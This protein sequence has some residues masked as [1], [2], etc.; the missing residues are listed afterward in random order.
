MSIFRLSR[1]AKDTLRVFLAHRESSETLPDIRGLL[2]KARVIHVPKTLYREVVE[3]T[4]TKML[5][6]HFRGESWA[7]E[8][9]ER[10]AQAGL[11]PGD[12]WRDE[13]YLPLAKTV[14]SFRR[15]GPLPFP[16]TYVGYGVAEGEGTPLASLL[17]RLDLAAVS[18]EDGKPTDV[19]FCYPF[20][21]LLTEE[22]DV[23]QFSAVA[24]YRDPEDIL[25]NIRTL[26]VVDASGG[27][28]AD[29]PVAA[30]WSLPVLM[31]LINSHRQF[32]ERVG[33]KRLQKKARRVLRG[34]VPPDFYVLPMRDEISRSVDRHTTGGVARAACSYRYDRRGHERC[35]VDR[36]PMPLEPRKA[37][38]YRKR[39]YRVYVPGK[40]LSPEDAK[41]LSSREMPPP[42][43]DEWLAIKEV[44]IDAVV[45]GDESLPYVPAVR[46]PTKGVSGV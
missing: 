8:E 17:D 18:R 46:V 7:R 31:D 21:H 27:R 42:G 43:P 16:V 2:K 19:K 41:R 12:R 3:Q 33:P 15:P 40:P 14:S 11:L 24:Y 45:V 10:S 4:T 30:N 36:D 5:D 37:E 29:S 35:Y 1:G 6:E 22:G 28:W 26:R 38:S 34:H 9:V 13:F 23:I 32:V 44:W 39:G 25:V 20:A